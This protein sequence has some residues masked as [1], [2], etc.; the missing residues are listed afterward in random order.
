MAEKVP[1]PKIVTPE[2]ITPEVERDWQEIKKTDA[3][4][5]S[6]VD[7]MY[8]IYTI[9]KDRAKA[10]EALKE[11]W[12]S[13][14]RQIWSEKEKQ[15]EAFREKYGERARDFIFEFHIREWEGL[16]PEAEEEKDKQFERFYAMD[17]KYEISTI[18]EE[19]RNVNFGKIKENILKRIE[20]EKLEDGH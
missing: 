2:E 12:A 17:T 4:L 9:A 3:E 13:L 8:K 15:L 5:Q 16:D 19:L 11:K 1:K 18:E 10:D 20:K 14:G 7:D 6:V